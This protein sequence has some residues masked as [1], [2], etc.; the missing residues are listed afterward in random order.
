MFLNSKLRS[1]LFRILIQKDNTDDNVFET[2]FIQ[3]KQE[4][5]DGKDKA[6]QILV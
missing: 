6:L 5:K 3:N 4:S 1:F 2:N